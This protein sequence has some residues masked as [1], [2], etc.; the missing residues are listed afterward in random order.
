MDISC[1]VDVG[2]GL[3]NTFTFDLSWWTSTDVEAEEYEAC[4]CFDD[5]P[6]ELIGHASEYLIANVPLRAASSACRRTLPAE[7]VLR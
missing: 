2:C 1:S 6:T 5:L 7:D 3:F 4:H